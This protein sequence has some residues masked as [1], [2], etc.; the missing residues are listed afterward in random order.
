MTTARSFRPQLSLPTT[1]IAEDNVVHLICGEDVRYTLRAGPASTQ[2]ADVLRRCDGKTPLDELLP[3][4]A[5][6]QHLE[7]FIQRL[8]SER[9]LIDGL[10]E[11]AAMAAEYSPVAE[12][13]GPIVEQLT[14]GA[15]DGPSIHIL[16]QDDL[17]YSAAYEFNRRH[18]QAATTPW[19]WITTGPVSRGYVSPVFLPDAGPCLACLLRQFQRLSPTAHLYDALITHGSDGGSFA[20]SEFNTDAMVVL[21]R[22]ACWKIDQMRLPVPSPA[23]FQLHVLE[24]ATMEVQMHRAFPDP[25][26]PECTDARL[27]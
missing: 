15:T 13:S 12:G 19:M 23:V 3:Q 24:L 8:T 11:D 5:Q 17:N 22:I 2:L 14:R 4:G 27:V 9:V 26:C 18:L 21:E 6:R 1:I 10:A 16:C 20:A 7:Q 25:T